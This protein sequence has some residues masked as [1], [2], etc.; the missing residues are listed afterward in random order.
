MT[1]QSTGPLV[2]PEQVSANLESIRS[3]DHDYRLLEVNIQ[4]DTDES[5]HIPGAISLNWQRDLRDTETFDVLSPEALADLLGECGIT[6]ETTIILYG[7]FFN[8]FAAHAFWLLRYYNHENLLLLNGSRKYWLEN[9]YPTT[10]VVPTVSERDYEIPEPDESI[11]ARR[12]EVEAAV[13]SGSCLLDVRAPPEYRGEILAPPGWNQGVQRGGHIPGAINRPC[14]DIVQA[15][16][17]FRPRS[18]LASIFDDLPKEE[19][20]IVYCRVG[21]RSALVWITLAEILGYEN[22]SYYY[23]SFVEWGNAVG[24]PVESPTS[25]NL[26]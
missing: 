12:S 20:I 21:E 13:E 4:E 26:R 11:R 17:R 16:R 2:A 14:R 3:D 8:W 24:L 18:E 10:D 7:D 9:G 5:G 23:G 25:A 1:L 15:D 6:R 19:E 22:V